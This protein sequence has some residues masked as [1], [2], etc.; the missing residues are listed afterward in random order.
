MKKI[1]YEIFAEEFIKTRCATQ[2]AKN[3]GY[4]EK[5][6]YSQGSR[7]LKHVEVKKIIAQ[8]RKELEANFYYSFVES[9]KNFEKAQELALENEKRPDLAAYIKAEELKGKLF[10]LYKAENNTQL[11]VNCMGSVKVAGRTLSLK[12]G[13]DNND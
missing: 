5:T 10:D 3:A 9:F 2:A 1:S 11:I 4:S 12:L 6:A 13:K 7:L 8:K